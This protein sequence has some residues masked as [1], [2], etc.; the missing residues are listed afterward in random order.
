MKYDVSFSEIITVF[1]DQLKL[2]P[3]PGPFIGRIAIFQ[4]RSVKLQ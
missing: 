1:D 3:D 4:Y 2:V